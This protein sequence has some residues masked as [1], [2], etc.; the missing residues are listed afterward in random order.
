M[1]ARSMGISL[2][3]A[4]EGDQLIRRIGFP[5]VSGGGTAQIS[6]SIKRISRIGYR[7]FA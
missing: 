6:I 3:Y 7:E 5:V 2:T 1:S 4:I